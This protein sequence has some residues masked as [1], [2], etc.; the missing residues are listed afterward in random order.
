MNNLTLMVFLSVI[1]IL[2][3]FSFASLYFKGGFTPLFWRTT[4]FFMVVFL[5]MS[6]LGWLLG[7]AAAGFLETLAPKVGA[8]LLLVISAKFF[9]R[10]AKTKTINR[11]FDID[12]KKTLAGL[13]I[14]INLDVLLYTTA[15]PMV[16]TMEAITFWIWVPISAFAGLL[17]GALS[18]KKT[19]LLFAN[20]SDLLIAA[21]LL[22]VGLVTLLS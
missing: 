17:L 21:I 7:N 10:G 12:Q 20:V 1:S 9:L 19:G 2:L 6:L 18:G 22:G 14:M 11:I 15:I 8:S 4:G 13:V 16:A 3:P 5:L